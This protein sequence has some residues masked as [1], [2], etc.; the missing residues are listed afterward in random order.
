MLRTAPHIAN[1]VNVR[2]ASWHVLSLTQGERMLKIQVWK[3]KTGWQERSPQERQEMIR[4][5]RKLIEAN[6]S[7]G[8]RADAGPFLVYRAE[9]VLL[10]W[11]LKTDSAQIPAEYAEIGLAQNFEPLT[12]VSATN[13]LT[14]K[15]LA[16][17]LTQ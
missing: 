17:R 4:R 6:L 16:E 5:L 13:T 12:F 7:N 2:A 11:T 3:A 9:D 8:S 14:A 15:S 1:D 10:L